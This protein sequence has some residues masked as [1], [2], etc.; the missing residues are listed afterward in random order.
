MIGRLAIAVVAA[1]AVGAQAEPIALG[2]ATLDLDE[3]WTGAAPSETRVVRGRGDATLVA[4][5]YEVPNV[6]AWRESTR[7]AHVD[8]I[9]AGFTGAGWTV[10][11]R[12]VSRIGAAAVPTLDLSLTRRGPRGRERTA[13]RV[14][15][16]RTMTWLAIAGGG[17]A[18]TVDGA[19]RALTPR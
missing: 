3:S 6:A 11:R 12:A 17:D 8:A 13:V 9:V 19:V 4:V 18:R 5:R 15:L 14:L 1:V 10:E 2:P 7:A 16:F